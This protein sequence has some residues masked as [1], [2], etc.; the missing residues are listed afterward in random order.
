MVFVLCVLFLS[1]N[2]DF[3]VS[4]PL[5]YVCVCHTQIKGDLIG[6][7]NIADNISD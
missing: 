4:T 1:P 7:D 3:R 5:F 6:L 2:T